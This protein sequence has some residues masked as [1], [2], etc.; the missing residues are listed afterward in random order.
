M[1]DTQTKHEYAYAVYIPDGRIYF[2]SVR[3]TEI[4]A[5]EAY[6][7][8]KSWNVKYVPQGYTVRPVTISVKPEERG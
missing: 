5:I 1:T 2:P 4:A 6:T 3:Q 7:S 8:L